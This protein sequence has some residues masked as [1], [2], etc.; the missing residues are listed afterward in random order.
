MSLTFTGY[1]NASNP[2][3]ADKTL[4]SISD[5]NGLSVVLKDETSV[6]K[7]TLLL[8]Y[9]PNISK[10]L[11]YFYIKEFE[12]W[13]FVTDI[14]AVRN[15]LI[16]ISG[17]TDVLSTAF[18]RKDE[19]NKSRLG[20]CE[21]ILYRSQKYHNLYINDGYFKVN[22]YPEVETHPF[23]KSFNNHSFVMMIAGN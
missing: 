19:N 16:E 6:Q 14:R 5:L 9:T 20:K 7:P 15:D 18:W 22:N 23:S 17:K 1:N 3:V 12:R 2:L 8:R 21:G 11:N 4:N 13:Y 10:D